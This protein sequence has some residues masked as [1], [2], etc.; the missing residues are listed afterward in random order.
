VAFERDVRDWESEA[1][2][3][4]DTDHHT[5]VDKEQDTNVSILQ[6]RNC[7]QTFMANLLV[8]KV[9]S[10]FL[11]QTAGGSSSE[12][13]SFVSATSSPA[14]QASVGAAH[15]ILRAA[16]T[17]HSITKADTLPGMFDFYPLDKL[18]FDAVVVCGHATLTGKVP[19]PSS[20]GADGSSLVEDIMSG[21][22]IL[23]EIGHDPQTWAVV[24][25][26]HKRVVS[27]R[28]DVSAGYPAN[29]L[30]RKH[31]QVDMGT[32]LFIEALT[33]FSVFTHC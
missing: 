24:D 31:N 22:N 17:L 33:E 5:T 13:S 28:A 9:Y 25:A 15:A 19:Y 21:V 11:R 20:F 10:P 30:K 23:Y 3:L 6:A 32:G 2:A 26:I 14:A 18:L 12:A 8:L 27:R 16:K 4:L 7:E 29:L 1:L